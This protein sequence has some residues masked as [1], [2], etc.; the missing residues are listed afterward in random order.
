MNKTD[1]INRFE[2]SEVVHKS[3]ITGINGIKNEM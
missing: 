1:K 3:G 2:L